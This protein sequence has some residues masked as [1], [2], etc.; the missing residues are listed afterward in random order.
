M[1]EPKWSALP[2]REG[3]LIHC[4]QTWALTENWMFDWLET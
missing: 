4:Q 3:A 2:P 1:A